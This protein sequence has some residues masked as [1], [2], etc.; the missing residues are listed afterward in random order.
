MRNKTGYVFIAGVM[1]AVLFLVPVVS[2]KTFG[3]GTEET[4]HC[5]IE[6]CHGV[7]VI[8]GPKPAQMCTMMYAAGDGCRR[9]A[10]CEII[11]GECRLRPD[12]RYEQCKECFQ[13]CVRTSSDDPSS[14]FQCEEQC[15]PST[16]SM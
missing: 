9:F 6:N 7:D 16:Q 3:I 5:G 8:C 11:D 2:A 14:A 13:E 12:P 15:V 4:V 1:M 10:V